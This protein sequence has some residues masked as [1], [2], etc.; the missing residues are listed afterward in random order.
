MASSN[1]ETDKTAD[2]DLEKINKLI[3]SVESLELEYQKGIENKKGDE[4]IDN[5]EKL[6][7][8]QT[9]FWNSHILCIDTCNEEFLKMYENGSSGEWTEC[10]KLT[11]DF[12]CMHSLYNR[13]IMK[14]WPETDLESRKMTILLAIRDMENFRCI[15]GEQF[16]SNAR[17]S[18]YVERNRH[19]L[20]GTSSME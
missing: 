4:K 2:F 18:L 13:N 15:S 1:T 7:Q 17:N 10:C 12:C 8:Y 14:D 5:N 19:N 20:A 11:W 16:F 6:L 3:T 9:D